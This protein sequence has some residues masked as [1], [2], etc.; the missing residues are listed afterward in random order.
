MT[1]NNAFMEKFHAWRVKVRYILGRHNLKF[2]DVA[3]G[4]WRFDWF[5]SFVAGCM[6]YEVVE[7]AL[8]EMR[9][10]GLLPEARDV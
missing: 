2:D 3:D 10:R 8:A 6:P 7:D 4:E 1:N 9:D 5:Q